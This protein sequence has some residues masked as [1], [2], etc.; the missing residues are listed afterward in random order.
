MSE[1]TIGKLATQ[2]DVSVE[3]I[4]YYERRGLVEAPGRTSGGFRLFTDDAVPR[5]RFIKR[6][7]QLGFSLE[8]IGELLNLREQGDAVC[9]RVH[10]MARSRIVQLNRRIRELQAAQR[11]LEAL[12][13]DCDA[14]VGADP[15]AV[16]TDLEPLPARPA[17]T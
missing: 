3:T 17:A 15:C 1:M 2:T 12:L 14:D 10:E 16:L 5:L 6:A 9:E 8:E 11:S 13:D 7:R 4:R